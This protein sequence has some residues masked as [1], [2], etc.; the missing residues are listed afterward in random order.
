ME[1]DSSGEVLSPYDYSFRVERA[2]G[3][4]LEMVEFYDPHDRN[5]RPKRFRL[6]SDS[7]IEYRDDAEQPDRG[8]LMLKSQVYLQGD[9]VQ[10][11]PVH[12]LP[13]IPTRTPGPTPDQMALDYRE[14]KASRTR[15]IEVAL[16]V[17]AA[18][19]RVRATYHDA[20]RQN[21][22]GAAAAGHLSIADGVKWRE[23]QI[24]MLRDDYE[25][26]LG[27]LNQ[28][29][30]ALLE[31]QSRAVAL[32]RAPAKEPLQ[33][34][35]GIVDALGTASGH[36]WARAISHGRVLD[37]RMNPRES[38]PNFPQPG[39][40]YGHPGDETGRLFEDA[41]TAAETWYE[42]HAGTRARLLPPAT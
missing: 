27:R 25:R 41:L 24:T 30:E 28:A 33:R 19:E 18:L 29:R 6:P 42:R 12:P 35:H 34:V 14:K 21:T 8:F 9:Q 26:Q 16:E 3:E 1:V 31:G 17:L 39:M 20:R 22:P 4:R 2:S 38:D 37:A 5:A 36:Y 7:I 15:G 23:K 10:V 11:E 32:W 40:L 13:K